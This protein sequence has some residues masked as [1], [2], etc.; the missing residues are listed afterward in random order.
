MVAKSSQYEVASWQLQLNYKVDVTKRSAVV[1]VAGA[2]LSMRGEKREEGRGVV[3]VE[4][5]VESRGRGER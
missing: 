4:A 2:F 3:Q 5:E 1:G